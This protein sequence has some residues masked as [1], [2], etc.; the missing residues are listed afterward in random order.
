MK[1]KKM[2]LLVSTA[3]VVAL[4]LTALP[5]LTGADQ[6]ELHWF[7]H[8]TGKSPKTTEKKKVEP[9]GT[10]SIT[11]AGNKFGPCQYNFVG[12][13]WNEPGGMGEGEINEVEG[14]IENCPT[15]LGAT[16]T[17]L[18][19]TVQ[20]LPMTLTLTSA[21]AVQVGKMTIQLHLS[22]GCMG[23]PGITT[24]TPSASGSPS[25]QFLNKTAT[26]KA[27][28]VFNNS[29]GLIMNGGAATLD[30][31]LEFGTELTAQPE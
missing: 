26:H 4:G 11:H 2:L 27:T 10:L 19:S 23:K 30:G 28:V 17:V 24:L 14:K 20:E 31:N 13:I 9:K 12:T 5:A 21:P 18:Q 22:N 29:G 15:S 7:D 8:Q 25:G 6:V 3:C 1:I 16:C